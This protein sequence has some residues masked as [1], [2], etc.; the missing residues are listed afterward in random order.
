MKLLYLLSVWP[1]PN[2]SA[3]GV[4]ALQFI[5]AL[6]ESGCE[7]TLC[8]ACRDNQYRRQLEDRAIQTVHYKLNDSSFDR[9]VAELNPSV[10]LFDRFMLEEQFSWRVRAVCPDARLVLDTVDLHCLRR[11][12][13]KKAVSASE[14]FVVANELS[15]EEF[16]TQDTLR[17]CA[18]IY[19]CDLSL[20]TSEYEAVL[21]HEKLDIPTELFNLVPLT[22][23]CSQVPPNGFNDRRHFVFIGNFH[24]EPNRDAVRMLKRFLWKEIRQRVGEGCELHVFGAY[25]D[26]E[27]TSLDSKEEGFRVYGQVGAVS[28]TLSRYR[29]NLAPLRFGAGQKGKISDGWFSGTPCVTTSIGAEGMGSWKEVADDS[30]SFAEKAARLYV[31]ESL[32][33]LRQKEGL[34]LII[35]RF[36]QQAVMSAFVQVLSELAHTPR[37]PNLIRELLWYHGNRS[38]EYFSKWIEEK[39]RGER[40]PETKSS[41]G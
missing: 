21:L 22:Y 30:T 31:D 37:R 20:L 33:S 16:V 15:Y 9:Y 4:R 24:H 36:N 32:W 25:P 23:P 6:V 2:S 10:V 41:E 12:R 26:S 7:L 29:V 18:S 27:I 28:E 34:E 14:G 19:R 11:A 40:E 8:S 17:E 38:T 5:E 39:N 13:Q 3:A 35:S 1:E